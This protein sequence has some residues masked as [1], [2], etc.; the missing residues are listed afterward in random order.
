LVEVGALIGLFCYVHATQKTNEI[1]WQALNDTRWNFIKEQRP[2]I[3]VSDPSEP[4]FVP[5]ADKPG[6]GQIVWRW[7]FTN[8]GKTPADK[9]TF[10]HYMKLG[11]G[12]FQLSYREE[13][14]DTTAPVPPTKQDYSRVISKPGITLKEFNRLMKQDGGIAIRGDL[15]YLDTGGQ[16]YETIFCLNHFATGEIQYCPGSAQNQIK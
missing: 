7:Y 6:T 1:A 2:Y 11:N 9:P 15:H 8:Y 16:P 12:Q 13:R 14:D 3:W 4:V 10:R 5:D